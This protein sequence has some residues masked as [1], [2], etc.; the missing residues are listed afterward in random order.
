MLSSRSK[1]VVRMAFNI[2]IVMG[3]KALPAYQA[4]KDSIF[5]SKEM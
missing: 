3:G 1:R 5:L 4:A 2:L